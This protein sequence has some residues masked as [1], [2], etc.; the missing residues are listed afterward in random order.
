MTRPGRSSWTGC[1]TASRRAPAA[2]RSMSDAGR[3]AT[4]STLPRRAG[5]SLLSTS[6]SAP[7]ATAAPPSASIS[8]T[9]CCAG[10][11]SA[12][13]PVSVA[14][15]SLTTTFAPARASA[16]ACSRPMPRPAPVTIATL[17]SRFG[18]MDVRTTPGTAASKLHVEER[19][20]GDA[21]LLLQGLGQGMWVW[22]DQV[23]AFAASFRTIAYDTRGTGRSPVPLGPY[24]I[25]DLAD[26][27]AEILGG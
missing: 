5:R 16:S 11:T 14:P 10:V 7:L 12:P 26:D 19:G 18:T 15:R 27:A 20:D 6:R 1:S 8:A 22:R 23:R 24:G 17:P 13:S 4:R 3:A 2:E 25:G 21:L 9:T